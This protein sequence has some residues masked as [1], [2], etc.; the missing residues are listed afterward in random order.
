[1]ETKLTIKLFLVAFFLI[2]FN[3]EIRAQARPYDVVNVEEVN[4]EGFK[5]GDPISKCKKVFG[6]PKE[7][8]TVD[9]S[10]GLSPEGRDKL[11][12]INYDSLKITYY[13][14]QN[15]KYLDDITIK[16]SKYKVNIGDLNISVGD[17]INVLQETFPNSNKYYLKQYSKPYENET[18]HFLIYMLIKHPE[19]EI[20]GLA[21]FF[22][23]KDIIKEIG[24]SF[25]E[26]A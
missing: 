8:K 18:Q 9:Q 5:Y 11:F 26:G 21:H 20:Y 25:G 7:Y 22:L 4:V 14:F 13:E 17:S 12:Y 1:M 24:L 16:S 19:Y 6:K 23:E 3:N 2:I 10:G 15:K